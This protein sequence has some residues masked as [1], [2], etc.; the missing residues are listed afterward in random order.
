MYAKRECR[1]CN[2]CKRRKEEF[3][4]VNNVICDKLLLVF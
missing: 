3:C 4:L 2:F 1:K